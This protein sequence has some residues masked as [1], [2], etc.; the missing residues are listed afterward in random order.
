MTAKTLERI[1]KDI[2]RSEEVTLKHLQQMEEEGH[3]IQAHNIF[4]GEVL[5]IKVDEAD[6]VA[7]VEVE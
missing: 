7:W 3:V 4:T 1:A 2:G 5:W 6:A